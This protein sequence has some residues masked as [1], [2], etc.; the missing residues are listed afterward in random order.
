MDR[1]WKYIVTVTFLIFAF[2]MKGM[3]PYVEAESVS[4]CISEV[5]VK[6]HA[7][8]LNTESK[9]TDWI[10]IENL[11]DDAISLEGWAISDGKNKCFFPAYE[12]KGHSFFTIQSENSSESM[13]SFGLSE[14][15]QLFL[16]DPNGETLLL[17]KLL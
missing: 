15:K 4:L 17:T 3:I 12:L 8:V 13:L 10:E 1:V 6:N 14:D 2:E 9:I 5:M 11:S 7:T 16:L